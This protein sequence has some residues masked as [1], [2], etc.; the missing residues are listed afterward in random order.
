MEKRLFTVLP[1]RPLVA[2]AWCAGRIGD[3]TAMYETC[4]FVIPC[5]VVLVILRVDGHAGGM[6]RLF[7]WL[8]D[9]ARTRPIAGF[10]MRTRL[11]AVER[12]FERFQ[13][14]V[15]FDE[16]DGDRR[17]FAPAEPG[18]SWLTRPK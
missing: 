16:G 9:V 7:A 4:S 6:R 5:P 15:T 12:V 1:L 14:R 17:W 3:Y 11:A 10:A 2:E 13:G 18:L 8:R